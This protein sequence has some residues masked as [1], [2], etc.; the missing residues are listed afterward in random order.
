MPKEKIGV[1]PEDVQG[2]EEFGK[3]KDNAAPTWDPLGRRRWIIYFILN[4]LL[5]KLN[6]SMSFL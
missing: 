5:K 1:V 6:M 3:N 4:K 2:L